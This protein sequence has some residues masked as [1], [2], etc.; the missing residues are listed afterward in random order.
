MVREF[1]LVTILFASLAFSL[2]YKEKRRQ[3]GTY[4]I[5]VILLTALGYYWVNCIVRG[6]N[7]L[8]PFLGGMDPKASDWYM[9]HVSFWN[10]LRYE[11]VQALGELLKVFSLFIPIFLLVRPRD[12][13]LALVFGGQIALTFILLPS[14]AGL[15]RYVMFTLPFLAIAYANAWER[16]PRGAPIVILLVGMFIFYPAQ[17]YALEKKFPSNFEG[18]TENLG[19]NDSVL[20][21]E[22]GQLA[23]RTGCKANWTSLFWSSDLFE[24]FEN[25]D[26]V[27]N[28]IKTHGI[29]HVLIDKKIILQ[30]NSSTIGNQAMGYPE[31]WVE[32]IENIGTKIRETQRY[33]L[34][35]V[36]SS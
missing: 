10:V 15:D 23:Y 6:Q 11:P 17:G 8:Y 22:Y 36:G 20:F 7:F 19:P 29:T 35:R 26:K 13:T 2:K 21:R 28:L 3:I 31:K 1:A 32:K 5:P 33:T 18:I 24:S 27:E 25:V 14:T 34:Y 30:T 9:S 16:L 12:K 4:L